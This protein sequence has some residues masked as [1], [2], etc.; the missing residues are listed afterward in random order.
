MGYEAIKLLL[1]MRI[2]YTDN[3]RTLLIYAVKRDN[4]GRTALIE[5]II[6]KNSQIVV[7]LIKANSD[8]NIKFG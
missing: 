5:A 4:K 1:D 8:T 3:N 6:A 7:C 2:N